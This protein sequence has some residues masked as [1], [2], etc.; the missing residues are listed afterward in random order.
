MEASY[1]KMARLLAGSALLV[2]SAAAVMFAQDAPA[3]EG[4]RIDI[5]DVKYVSVPVTVFT[6]DGNF[7]N[8]LQPKD[9]R[10]LDN[11]REQ[12]ILQDV[13]AQPVSVVVVIQANTYMEGV[14]PQIHKI[15]SLLDALV[16]GETGEAAVVKFDHR[17]ETVQDFTTDSNQIA[18]A[19]KKIKP[20]SSTVRLNDAM[21]HAINMLRSKPKGRRRVILTIAQTKDVGSEFRPRTVLEEAQFKDVIIYSVNVSRVMS[22]L[23]TRNPVPPRPAAIPPA[24]G[25]STAGGGALNPTTQMQNTGIGN[26]LPLFKEIFDQAKGLFVDN[27]LE[28]YTKWTGGREYGF[29]S[30]GGLERAVSH[31]GDEVH[32]QYLLSYR[33]PEK[34]EGGYHEIRVDVMRPDLEVRTRPGYWIA[35]PAAE[36]SK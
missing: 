6:K 29:V 25:H 15:G 34:A 35:G 33:L 21:M 5:I 27:P 22:S 36:K 24:A 20:G 4:Q 26:A 17:I 28:V 31:I 3:G 1:K 14:L 11:G 19:I 12:K 9:F 10:V 18:E 32:S 8:G 7:V 23:T 2:A 30:Q 13:E 16:V